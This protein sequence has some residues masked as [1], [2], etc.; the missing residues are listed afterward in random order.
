MK[1]KK[2][3]LLFSIAIV[4]S[5]M[6][7]GCGQ[8]EKEKQSIEDLTEDGE[9]SYQTSS[10]GV[11]SR[12]KNF[13]KK[14]ISG[15][16]YVVQDGIYY[17]LVYYVDNHGMSSPTNVVQPSRQIYFTT[18]DEVEIPV[19]FDDCELI[20]YSKEGILDYMTWERYYDLGYTIGLLDLKTMTSGRVYLD[21][22]D[23]KEMHIIPDSELF[24]INE[25]KAEKLLVDK[26]GGIQ[27]TEDLISDGLILS[28]QK[29]KQYDLEIY[30]GTQYVHYL[31]TANTHAFK[32]YELFASI[33]Y[34][35]IK[36]GFFKIEIPEYLVTGYYS[37]NDSGV[38]KLVRGSSYSP[39]TDFNEQLLYP[40]L[41]EKTGEPIEKA[42][43]V[44]STYEPLNQFSTNQEG[45]LGYVDKD[46]EVSVDTSEELEEIV[47]KE[48]VVKEFELFFPKDRECTIQIKTNS[49][50][51]GGDIYLTI[52]NKVKIVHYDAL[53]GIYE[54]TI[55]GGNEKGVLTVTG[56][57][58]NYNIT[59]INCETYTN[60]LEVS[61]TQPESE[62]TEE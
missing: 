59:L 42:P 10:F 35:T 34:E 47:L 28:T 21:L 58:S 5:A 22:S 40:N 32:A 52:G 9:I 53:A 51:S 18:Q 6:L 24:E 62:A 55:A 7:T 61:E 43:R 8:R 20:Y 31:A 30:T 45:K 4:F 26:I 57:S 3:G 2:I 33:E 41:D 23:E 27:V 29:S 49:R 1:L 14:L 11:D 12:S 19:L 38:F 54:L 17:P 50:D 60:Q 44:Y 36:E 13:E 46:S 16:Y 25:L 56:L 39:D 15:S 37:L 48:A